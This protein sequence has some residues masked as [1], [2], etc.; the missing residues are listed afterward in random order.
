MTLAA[1]TTSSGTLTRP[2]CH[3]RITVDR[4]GG[5]GALREILAAFGGLWAITALGWL[6]GRYGLLGAD[7]AATLARLVFYV[8]APA[9]LVVTLTT[10]PL[11][12]VF[13]AAFLPFLA[14]TAAVAA[15][16]LALARWRWRLPA[17]EA[18]VT[19]LTASYVNGGY[20]GIP[21]AGYVLGDVS[22]AVPV[23]LFQVLLA[24]PVALAVLDAGRGLRGLAALPA[25]NP[26][27]A[28]CATGL[29]I[30]VSGWD[31]PPEVLRPFE[32]VGSAAIPLALIAL[33]LSLGGARPLRNGP[34][35]P[36][37]FTVVALKVVVQPAVAY[38]VGRHALGLDGIAL[39]AAVVMSALPTAQNVF[40]Y[41]TRFNRMPG[42]AR[43][44][45][46]LSTLLAAVSLVLIALWLG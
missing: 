2:A 19:T 28:A 29:A 40:V 1:S 26:V 17:G 7:A 23:L 34:D 41:A 4:C 14:S 3:A 21:V 39:L 30:A 10:T 18:T 16:A 13:T 5:G 11:S 37:R 32:L 46:V 35:A 43:D 45:V 38:L 42:L 8:A 36:M 44:A 27:I 6:I 9:L 12:G 24:S 15:V 33:G 22:Y 20:L 25:R 31:P